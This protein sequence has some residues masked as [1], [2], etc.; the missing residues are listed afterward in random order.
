[1]IYPQRQFIRDSSLRV[2]YGQRFPRLIEGVYPRKYQGLPPMESALPVPDGSWVQEELAGPRAAPTPQNRVQALKLF[3]TLMLAAEKEAPA[4]AER[5]RTA[6]ADIRPKW[7]P[8]RIL[9]HAVGVLPANTA[10]I[11]RAQAA[12]ERVEDAEGPV[13]ESW[14]TPLL[15]GGGVILIGGLL[16]ALARPARAA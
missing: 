4:L 9:E 1:M 15:V 16:M 14:K 8:K 13:P 2:V 11:E 12:L 10:V 3:R 7:G 6:E 5:Y